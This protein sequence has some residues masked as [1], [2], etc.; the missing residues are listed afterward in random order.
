[1]HSTKNP[2]TTRLHLPGLAFLAVL[3]LAAVSVSPA[4]KPIPTRVSLAASSGAWTMYHHDDGHTGY[5]STLPNATGASTGWVSG[6]LDQQV[7]ASPLVYNGVVYAATLNNTV[8]A[9]NQATGATI[10]SK[11]LGAPQTS[12]WCNGNVSPMGI[13]GTPVIDTTANRIYAAALLTG[14][15]PTYHLFGLDLATSGTVVLDTPIAPAGFDWSVQQERGALAIRGGNVYVPFGGRWGDCGAYH[16]WVFGVSTTTGAITGQYATTGTGAGFWAAGGVVIDDATN[17]VFVTSGNG[18]SGCAANPNGTPVIEENSVL[19]LSTTL[20]LEDS[21]VPQDWHTP[22]CTSDEDLGGAGPLL[23][24]SNL[25]FQAGKAGGG[26][27]LNPSALGGMDGQLFPT[28]KPQAY[29]QADMCYGN[30][31]DATFGSFAYAAPF[32]YLQ[33][34]GGRGLVGL[35]T[36]TGAPSFSVCDLTCAPPT[37]KAGYGINFGP[38]I[39]AGGAVWAASSGGGL[40]AFNA[41]TGAQLF[42]SANFGINNF[43]TPAEA[44]G[45]VFVPSHTVIRSFNMSFASIWTSLGGTWTSAPEASS[46]ASNHVDVFIRGT[47]NAMWQ[48]SWN[49]SAWSASTSLGGILTADPGAVSWGPNRNDM[50]VRGTDNQMWHKF[51]LAPGVWSGWEP[52]G[53]VLTSGPD[54]ASWGSGRLDVF[55]RGSDNALWHKWWDGSSWN[56]WE[57]LGGVLT[58]DPAAVSWGPNRVDVFVRGLDN[59]IWHKWWDGSRWNGWDGMGGNLTSAP[60]ATSCVAGHLDMFATGAGSSLMQLGF[61]GGWGVWQSLGGTWASRPGAVC[62]PGTNAV[63]LFERGTDNALWQASVPGS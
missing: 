59:G 52:L 12:G 45:Q 5:D 35:N 7:Y 32:I 38:P 3:T 21:F 34:N 47:D 10:W 14:S 16:G 36:N 44:G 13:L 43:V 27:L 1:M 50:F 28:P 48:T 54:V 55:V 39:V 11:N 42:H 31:S 9:L 58:S 23:I 57:S 20:A 49:G 51:G 33:C 63:D 6:V 61:N 2:V 40:Y 56:G 18:T 53:G 60:E 24:S 25:L 26:F 46:W 62:Q 19:R 4:N 22:Y 37:W 15:T 17:K 29:S 30:H 8:Y 41:T